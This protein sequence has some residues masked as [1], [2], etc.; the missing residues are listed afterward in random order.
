MGCIMMKILK[1]KSVLEPGDLGRQGTH[2]YIGCY[3]VHPA[4]RANAVT[5]ET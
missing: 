1:L 4:T 3:C 5:V 2:T